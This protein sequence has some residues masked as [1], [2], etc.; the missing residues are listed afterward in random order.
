MLIFNGIYFDNSFEILISKRLKTTFK[1]HG[2]TVPFYVLVK[3][4]LSISLSESLPYLHIT[5][6]YTLSINIYAISQ[7]VNFLEAI[8]KET[9][10]TLAT[11]VLYL[12]VQSLSVY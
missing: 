10:T 2:S 11:T 6:S 8:D 9:R 4:F 3:I 12:V 1:H 7:S 5:D